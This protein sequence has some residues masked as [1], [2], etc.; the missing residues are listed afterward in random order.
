MSVDALV[1]L[2][3]QCAKPAVKQDIFGSDACTPGGMDQFR[4]NICSLA[5]RLQA[6]PSGKGASVTGLPS[7]KEV[8]V[9]RGRKEAV[10]DRHKGVPVR[11]AKGEHP[12]PGTVF[13]GAVVED[14]CE[15]LHLFRAGTVEQA[16]VNNEDILALLVRQRLHE[17]VDDP[18]RKQCRETLPV[19]PGVVKETVDGVLGESFSKCAC[20][21]LHI[22]APVGEHHTEQETE[23]I[24][25]RNPLFL[26]GITLKEQLPKVE[27]L[28][29]FCG[30][31]RNTVSIICFL[32]YT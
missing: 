1:L 13:H 7:T 18:G 15:Q 26:S 8:L 6:S 31:I 25:Y 4:H 2:G 20:L 30:K 11:P 23:D 17:A 5:A 27:P 21:H 19:C 12:E 9:L 28:H 14:P 22:E 32:W 29:K 24:H 3:F 16:V 10:A